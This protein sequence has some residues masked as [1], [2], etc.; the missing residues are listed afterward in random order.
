MDI[1]H[2]IQVGISPQKIRGNLKLVP[3]MAISDA[4]LLFR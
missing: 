3:G 1:F 4:E 2:W